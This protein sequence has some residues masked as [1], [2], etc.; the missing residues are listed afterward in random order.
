MKQ[1]FRIFIIILLI[2][3]TLILVECRRIRLGRMRPGLI[4][5]NRHMST[6]FTHQEPTVKSNDNSTLNDTKNSTSI[7]SEWSSW[8]RCRKRCK[9][10]RTRICIQSDQCQSNIQKEERN[11]TG[12]R[13]RSNSSLPA[14]H[15]QHNHHHNHHHHNHNHQQSIQPNNNGRG[16]STEFKVLYHL[17]SYVYSQWSKWSPCTEH[18][19]TRRYR[20]CEMKEICGNSTIHEDA[21]CAKKGSNCEKY[22]KSKEEEQQVQGQQ[23]DLDGS[24]SSTNT[25]SQYRQ[26][27]NE[28]RWINDETCGHSS[29]RNDLA[30][31]LRIIGGREANKGKWPWIVAILNRN[32]EAFCGGTLITSQFVITAAHCVRRRLYIRAGEHDLMI[33]EGSEQQEQVSSLFV[34][35]EYD[36]D[37]VDNDIALLKLRRPLQMNR[38]VSP[39]CLPTD[40]DILPTNSLGTILGWGKRKNSAMFGSD[41]LHQA[42]VPI[43]DNDDCRNV[44]KD[45]YMISDN[46]VC[47]GYKKGKIDSCAGDSGGPLLFSK[48]SSTTATTM[49]TKW[50]LYGI[51]S[52]GE[53]CGKKNKYGIYAKV[54]NVVQW[55]RK[56][57]MENLD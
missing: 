43:A 1:I 46:M 15:H 38:F 31:M 10:I 9:Q 27:I 23:Y 55:V 13:C 51:T 5:M 36:P 29:I 21:I 28:S 49:D 37:T 52:F 44:Y 25:N 47:A 7:Y 50:F 39:I 22:F 30:S 16:R 53:G 33:P 42:Q 17:Q 41:V 14:H 24:S 48:K 8:S 4:S 12:D 19:Q 32:H 35:P 57:I 2:E 3:S 11:C 54:P 45:K 6:I 34:H 26:S 20:T 40:Q 18:C 56:T